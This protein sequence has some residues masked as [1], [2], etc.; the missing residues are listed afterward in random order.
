MRVLVLLA[1]A[2]AALYALHRFALWAESRGY[3]YYTKTSPSRS[4]VGNAFL[5][6]HSLIEPDKKALVE[7]IREE[8]T[9]Q[10]ESGEP[11][12]PAK[13]ILRSRTEEPD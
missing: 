3:I 8:R 4:S 7:V 9:E 5:E 1:A 12:H 2:A 10:D 13:G 6:V 11:P